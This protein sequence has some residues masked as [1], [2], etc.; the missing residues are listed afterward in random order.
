[1]QKLI[2]EQII[3]IVT[4]SLAETDNEILNK[5]K[6]SQL[7]IL[8]STYIIISVFC[9]YVWKIGAKSIDL[10]NKSLKVH[11]TDQDNEALRAAIPYICGVIFLVST[12]F[13]LKFLVQSIIP[14]SKDIK[15]GEKLLLYYIPAKLSAPPFKKYYIS[16]P[17]YKN[18]QVEVS[19]DEF[20]SLNESEELCLEVAPGS[21]NV[22]RLTKDQKVIK[23]H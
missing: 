18:Q 20:E 22:L 6:K 1:M 15:N 16:T 14:I 19:K 12:F 2:P 8:L 5:I 21:F 4:V 3:R 10:D 13:F 17:L 23:Y 9:M 7:L 11:F